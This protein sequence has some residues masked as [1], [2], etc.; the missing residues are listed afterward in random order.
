MITFGDPGKPIAA[1]GQTHTK[2]LRIVM[3]HLSRSGKFHR[4]LP[5]VFWIVDGRRVGGD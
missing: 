3:G 2:A 1:I 4:W 5:D